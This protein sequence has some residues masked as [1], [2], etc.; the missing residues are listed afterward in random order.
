MEPACLRIRILWSRALQSWEGISL[1]SRRRST[2]WNGKGKSAGRC[3]CKDMDRERSVLIRNMGKRKQKKRSDGTRSQHLQMLFFRGLG[4]RHNKQISGFL[5]CA[6]ISKWCK[7]VPVCPAC[8]DWFV[9]CNSI[10]ERQIR[11]CCRYCLC[12]QYRFI[13]IMSCFHTILITGFNCYKFP[14]LVTRAVGI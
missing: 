2:K 6:E 7:P 8:S 1:F 14:K 4:M 12:R 11:C 10:S 3:N 9:S 13:C 5:T